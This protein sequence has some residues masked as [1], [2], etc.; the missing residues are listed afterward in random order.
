MSTEYF[1]EDFAELIPAAW[2]AAL[3]HYLTTDSFRELTDFLKAEYTSDQIFPPISDLFTAFRLTAPE[4]VKVVILGQDPYHDDGQAHGLAFSVREGVRFPPS[5][6]N[7]FK[8]LSADTGCEIPQQGILT[9]WAEQGVLLLN[10]VLTVRAHNAGSHRNRGWECL[11]DEVIRYL[12][13]KKENL[14]FVLWGAPAQ[15]KADLIDLSRHHVIMSPHPSPLSA[16]RGFFGSRPFSKINAQ[17]RSNGL[18][19][20]DWQL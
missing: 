14:I 4:E 5:L 17:L 13:S 3:H 7:I 6:R 19:E 11:T 15:K 2:Q 18:K 10:T 1:P 20:I 16:H 9:R 8:E 12:N